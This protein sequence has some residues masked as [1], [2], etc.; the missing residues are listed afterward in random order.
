MV[1]HKVILEDCQ[2][3][4]YFIHRKCGVWIPIHQVVNT[5]F[6]SRNRCAH[7]IWTVN[8]KRGL[9][10]YRDFKEMAVVKEMEK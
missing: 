7:C 4:V 6:S 10:L 2:Y 5:V 9:E 3:F 1:S 8:L